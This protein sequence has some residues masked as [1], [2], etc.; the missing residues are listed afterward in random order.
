MESHWRVPESGAL[1][2]LL[3]PL[4]GSQAVGPLP[5]SL[6]LPAPLPVPAPLPAAAAQAGAP[7]IVAQA[8]AL[9]DEELARA[10]LNPGG[11]GAVPW[12]GHGE[13]PLPQALSD[14]ARHLAAVWSPLQPPASAHAVPP[15]LNARLPVCPGGRT[16]VLM[17]L[18]NGATRPQRLVPA[19][20]DLLGPRGRRIPAARLSLDAPALTLAPGAEANLA[21]TVHVP[22]DATVGRY[23]GLLVV[24]YADESGDPLHAMVCIDVAGPARAVPTA[25]D[26]PLPFAAPAA[27]AGPTVGFLREAARLAADGELGNSDAI[28]L[29]QMSY[30]PDELQAVLRQFDAQLTREARGKLSLALH[31]PLP[32]GVDNQRYEPLFDRY[33]I[34][35]RTY[36]TASGTVVPVEIQY[37]NGEMV[38]VHGEC[39]Q[40][41]LVREAL[42]GS[43]YQPL[44]LRHVD[45]SDTA[46]AQF[47]CHRLADTSLQPYDAAFVIVAAVPEGPV[48]THARWPAHR[49]GASCLLAMTEGSFDA[50]ARRYHNR[51]RLFYVRLLDSTRVAIEVGRER[52]GTDKRPGRVEL[53]RQGARRL[54]TVS[55]G[56]DQR[57]AQIEFERPAA[58]GAADAD[59][60]AA[61]ATAGLT[62]QVL[63]P[64]TECVF[65]CVARIGEEPVS[66]WSWHSDV[67]P[68]LLRAAPGMVRFDAASVTGG[69]LLRWGFE[70]KWLGYIPTLRG[71]VTGVA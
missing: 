1:A 43:G 50:E 60:S 13:T 28:R 23:T 57:V 21:I 52:M 56:N 32:D 69:L 45:G 15:T 68:R 54:F 14:V 71:V 59:L 2:G 46:V 6:P 20:T 51:T 64:G 8:A 33:P 29:L 53:L 4:P 19:V 16:T 41:A 36:T 7:D 58:A 26:E 66:E 61:A 70:P 5:A 65:P 24:T 67:Q 44:L 34:S 10:A 47:W 49:N 12:N 48:D 11:G 38:Q 40:P 27:Q 17:T 30:R 63:P 3:L 39:T 62:L 35:G 18:R 31:T 9:L 55:E 25:A 22:T 42:A 37:Y